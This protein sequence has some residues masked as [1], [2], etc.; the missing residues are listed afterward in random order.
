MPYANELPQFLPGVRGLTTPFRS[1][2]QTTLPYLQCR[3][4][5]PLQSVVRSPNRTSHTIAGK[6]HIK[7]S[8]LCR[9]RSPV[10]HPKTP[11][12]S[13]P[14]PITAAAPRKRA[15][16]HHYKPHPSYRSSSPFKGGVRRTGDL[17]F[18]DQAAAVTV[19]AWLGLLPCLPKAV[20]S[21]RRA[22]W[23]SSFLR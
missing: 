17:A 20:R 1:D 19:F 6:L 18:T 21:S 16:T 11:V 2:G 8:L 22:G 5:A 9:S 7:R 14:R 4:L 15:P 23:L 10:T 13:T 12:D 3:L